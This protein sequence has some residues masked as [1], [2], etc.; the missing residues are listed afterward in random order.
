MTLKQIRDAIK[1]LYGKIIVGGTIMASSEESRYP[2]FISNE[3]FGGLHVYDSIDELSKLAVGR[4]QVGMKATV[5]ETVDHPRTTYALYNIPEGVDRISD[6]PGYDISQYW[7]VDKFVSDFDGS[8]TTQYAPNCNVLTAQAVTDGGGEPPST[9]TGRPLVLSQAEYDTL[10]VGN[11]VLI[12]SVLVEGY[13]SD[14]YESN[15][16]WMR[17]KN[18]GVWSNPMKISGEGYEAG[19]YVENRFKWSP[20]KP[21]TPPTYINGKLNNTPD[22][23]EDTPLTG[24][25]KL[26][27]IK[28]LKDVYQ[29]LRETGWREPIEIKDDAT[30]VRYN[31]KVT[32]N[33]NDIAYADLDA[34]GWVNTYDNVDHRFMATRTYNGG[35]YSQ[36]AITKIKDESG[37]YIEYV[38]KAFPVSQVDVI[39]DNP[40]TYRPNGS[41]PSGWSDVPVR[42]ADDEIQFVST[43]RK[44]FNG[45]LINDWSDPVPFTG[46]DIVMDFIKS[47]GGDEFKKDKN[48]VVTPSSLTLTAYLYRGVNQVVPDSYQWER[49][50]NNGGL[51]TT[52]YGVNDSILINATDVIG[53]AIFKCTQVFGGISYITE[54]SIIDISDGIDSKSLILTSNSQ[55]ITKKADNSR[56]P[57]AGITLRAYHQNLNSD[58]FEW[59]KDGVVI[60]GETSDTLSVVYTDFNTDSEI[61]YTCSCD[62]LSD[63]YTIYEVSEASG[64]APAIVMVLSNEA[65]TVVEDMETNTINFNGASTVVKVYEGASDVTGT[66]TY[67]KVDNGVTSTLNVSDPVRPTVTITGMSGTAGF[68]T[69]TGSKDGQ[70]IIKQFTISKIKDQVGSIILDIDSDSGYTFTPINR[71]PKTLTA[72][73]YINGVEATSGVTYAWSKDGVSG[74]TGKTY[75][76]IHDS[77]NYVDVVK[78][79]ATY[80]GKSYSRSVSITDVKDGKGMGILY[81][82][83]QNELTS[84]DK[85]VGAYNISSYTTTGGIV[86]SNNSTGAVWMSI[87]KEGDTAWSNP[88]RVKGE[89]GEQGEIGNFIKNIFRRSST[90]PTT[91]TGN[92]IPAGWSDIPPDGTQLLWVSYGEITGGN[93]LIGNWTTPTQISGDSGMNGVDGKDGIDGKDGNPT[94]S[95]SLSSAAGW[96]GG[97]NFRDTTS[98]VTATERSWVANIQNVSEV[99]KSV[100]L[101]GFAIVQPDNPTDDV[102]N[103]FIA[104]GS[105]N[106]PKISENKFI[107]TVNGQIMTL[108][109][110]GVDAIEPGATASYYIVART[111]TGGM[112][113]YWGM[114]DLKAVLL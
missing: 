28:G 77:A 46:Q 80:M 27:M 87:K 91:P 89:K 24:T 14:T 9:K 94:L 60:A 113:N 86:W 63:N 95:A 22:G 102:I 4:M 55:I 85:P 47:S 100:L 114:P 12:N 79:I 75:T 40:D 59:K 58:V 17:M 74:G 54:Y 111:T 112:S 8:V 50:F 70:T 35:V 29:Q 61:T 26:W 92:P 73:L 109:I 36:W 90:R 18:K 2:T 37:E 67:S 6:I 25:G 10:T 66:W 81:T 53:K 108:P 64:G 101:I 45:E 7:V 13:W 41:I 43:G 56:L 82:T 23:W 34:N 84:M 16:V 104:K 72:K 99:R 57:S 44:F 96:M 62:E 33:P 71:A 97:G 105:I 93:Q 88:V 32:P 5:N 30:T 11:S 65:H 21:S 1:S 83:S 38:F 106:G 69:I 15:H 52:D 48:G 31:S 68:V 98:F 76:L 3:G 107:L 20:T 19:D 51:D 39:L 110:V 103:L 42:E 78:C 49:I